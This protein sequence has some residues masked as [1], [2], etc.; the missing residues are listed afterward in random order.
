MKLNPRGFILILPVA[1]SWFGISSNL[2]LILISLFLMAGAEA[3]RQY[4]SVSFVR[5]AEST[6]QLFFFGII[7]KDTRNFF[8]NRNS[9][10]LIDFKSNRKLLLM[11]GV[12]ILSLGMNFS[13]AYAEVDFI[14]SAL[15]SLV[16]SLWVYCGTYR[17]LNWVL[18]LQLLGSSL[19]FAASDKG[20][21]AGFTIWL[22]FS[23]WTQLQLHTWQLV[24]DSR[25]YD[26]ENV[27]LTSA[28]T[29]VK[30]VAVSVVLILCFR[31]ADF[32]IPGG[33][34]Q[35]QEVTVSEDT[36]SSTVTLTTK[37]GKITLPKKLLENAAK[38][39]LQA[40]SVDFS[41]LNIKDL[42]L[43][44]GGM[45][46]NPLKNL[47]SKFSF[48]ENG[49]DLEEIKNNLAGDKPVNPNDLEKLRE[50]SKKIKI[51]PSGTG[52]SEATGNSKADGSRPDL[53]DKDIE[54]RIENLKGYTKDGKQ[55]EDDIEAYMRTRKELS[56][57]LEK[58]IHQDQKNTLEK[59]E[60]NLQRSIEKLYEFIKRFFLLIVFVV[61]ATWWLSRK[62]VMPA[63]SEATR[64]EKSFVLSKE[65]R[66]R[67]KVL[68]RM[69]L[70]GN[71][72]PKDEVLKSY[73]IVELAFKEFEFARADDLPPLNFLE[74]LRNEL[75]GL[76]KSAETP[77]ELFSR[78]FYGDKTPENK[79]ILELRTSMQQ[80]MKK[81]LVI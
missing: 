4:L 51:K 21:N 37:G 79:E 14:Y 72:S 32:I 40:G 66:V 68:Y 16:I 45:S 60:L 57:Q 30:A 18:L 28:G 67:L 42:K 36:N 64:D 22:V 1:L 74:K 52:G 73:Y 56:D 8:L 10:S 20:N 48:G 26:N 15:F 38:V 43:S 31:T 77:I 62:K 17:L 33:D 63:E 75:P 9:N 46:G 35:N 47:S 53:L 6:G 58:M 50:L 54:D 12:F 55:N 24:E 41:K 2:Q 69:L 65:V 61:L 34:E 71:F 70:K 78:V 5:E 13:P 81:L 76:S 3:L 19:A 11:I 49:R 27:L 39:K 7:Y 59:E 29:I 80:L 25:R 44:S 23:L